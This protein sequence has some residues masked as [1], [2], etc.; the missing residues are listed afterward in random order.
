MQCINYAILR[1]HTMFSWARGECHFS[2]RKQQSGSSYAYS[3]NL[4]SCHN[5]QALIM[6]ILLI[7]KLSPLFSSM[8]WWD[9]IKYRIF[10]I[11]SILHKNTKEDEIF[12]KRVMR[13]DSSTSYLNSIVKE[14]AISSQ[15]LHQLLRKQIRVR[16]SCAIY[17]VSIGGMQS[18]VF[19]CHKS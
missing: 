8:F 17:F 19:V 11:L 15:N 3:Q 5:T 2:E 10:K 18:Q 12:I 6:F 7:L 16:V 13:S 14:G 9:S 1:N 4:L